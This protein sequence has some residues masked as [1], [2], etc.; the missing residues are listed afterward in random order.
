MKPRTS[1]ATRRSTCETSLVTRVM[2][3]PVVKASVC[4]NE[5]C[6][7]RSKHALRIR[8]P[9][10]W[11]HRLDIVPLSMPNSPP[12]RTIRII[13]IPTVR[14]RARSGV[15]SPDRPRMPLSTIS[16]ISFGWIISTVTSAIMKPAARMAKIQYLRMYFSIQRFLLQHDFLQHHHTKKR[17]LLESQ[18]PA[19]TRKQG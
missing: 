17:F 16:A 18:I 8:L 4:S 15:P 6:M 11:L 12:A 14:I 19:C 1:C 9:K 7:I 2:S 13:R 3:E 10:F 5:R